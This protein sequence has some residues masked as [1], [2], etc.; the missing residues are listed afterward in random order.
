ME[1]DNVCVWKS[2]RDRG[3]LSIT[4]EN[5]KKIEKI[6]GNTRNTKIQYPD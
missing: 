2:I 1:S 6:F 3:P 4:E 5:T